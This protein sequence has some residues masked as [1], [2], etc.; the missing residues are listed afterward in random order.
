MMVK[1]L[2]LA[3]AALFVA[4]AALA[5]SHKLK[6]LEIVHP[7]CIETNDTADPVSVFMTI[8]NS[9]RPDK[10]L[11]ATT[12]IAGKSELR[13]AY[14]K[15]VSSVG[16][17]TRGATDLKRDGPHI[18]LLDVRKQLSPYDS[19]LMTLVFERAGKVEVE[20]MVEKASIL[21]PATK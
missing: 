3:A 9:G 1:T 8:K 10:L 5:H 13:V 21:A 18:Q 14:D 15:A 11:R 20:V 16:V 7:W 2:A 19:F 6:N 17:A 12:S 4:T